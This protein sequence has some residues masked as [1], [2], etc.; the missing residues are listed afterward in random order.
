MRAR[1]GACHRILGRAPGRWKAPRVV[2]HR[3][4]SRGLGPGGLGSTL[5]DHSDRRA[6]CEHER[7]ATHGRRLGAFGSRGRS[8]RGVR[9]TVS[10]GAPR[11]EQALGRGSRVELP[12]RDACV[13]GKT[14][15]SDGECRETLPSLVV[16]RGAQTPRGQHAAQA[17]ETHQERTRYGYTQFRSGGRSRSDA[18]RVLVAEESQGSAAN[19]G[20]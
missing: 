18:S 16:S 20:R 1:K 6:S 4:L 3:A 15:R 19:A 12:A 14:R 5:A 9:G 8:D 7:V 13:P 17:A 2:T 10:S 11:V